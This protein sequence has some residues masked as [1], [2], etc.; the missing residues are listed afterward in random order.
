MK[1]GGRVEVGWSA[2]FTLTPRGDRRGW[3][4]VVSPAPLTYAEQELARVKSPAY[5]EHLH[6]TLGAEPSIAAKLAR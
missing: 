3:W 6:G 2:G 1:L 5:L 4:L